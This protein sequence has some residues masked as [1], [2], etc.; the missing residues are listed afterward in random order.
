MTSILLT[1]GN[2]MVGRNFL[3]A[4]ARRGL[5]VLA[6]SRRDLDLLDAGATAAY[7]G[8]HRPDIV[9]HA[10]GRVGGIQANIAAP[11]A[12]L[13]ENWAMGQNL[14]LAARA[15]G[16][17]SLINLGS[18]CMYPA[19]SP[20]PL[21]EEQILSGALEPTNEGYA[22]AKCAVARLCQ[23]VSREDG[24]FAYKTIIPSNLYGPHDS[25]DPAR[26]H[27]VPAIIHKLHQ[28]KM[29]G[30]ETVEIWGT[31]EARREFLYAGDLAEALIA[32]VGD[33]DSLPDLLN[34]G[35]GRD[36]TVNEHYA[37]AAEV[38][39]WQGRFVHDL[40]KPAGMRRKLLDVSRAAAWGF[41]AKTSLSEGI[42]LAYQ[43]YLTTG[44]ADALSAR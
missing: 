1:G 44:H 11:V 4:C 12:F 19:D 21:K 15:A 13:T 36:V 9:I 32:A 23:Y 43:Y 14:V 3:D 28:A 18:S 41:R 30:A 2:G 10:A 17:P 26:S 7:L 31:G 8:M 24:R 38:I 20:D 29:S 27:L 22:I 16:I 37:I 39:G 33:F 5:P 40:E 42:A 6:P 34:I 35:T 25:F